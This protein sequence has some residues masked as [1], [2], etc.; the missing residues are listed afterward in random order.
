MMIWSY[1]FIVNE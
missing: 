1:T